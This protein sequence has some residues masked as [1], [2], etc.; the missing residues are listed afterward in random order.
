MKYSDFIKPA[1]SFIGPVTGGDL[2]G[3]EV[4]RLGY[5]QVQ[6]FV[7]CDVLPLDGVI[8]WKVQG[9]DTSGGTFADVTGAAGDKIT[10]EDD[11]IV[12][13][14]DLTNIALTIAAQPSSP[15]R[16]RIEVVDTTP[17][18]TQGDVTIVGTDILDNALTEVVSYTGGAVKITSGVFK[19]IESITCSDFETL[20]GASDETIEVGPDNSTGVHVGALDGTQLPRYLRLV[21][22]NVTGGSGNMFGGFNLSNYTRL[23]DHPDGFG[24]N[25]FVYLGG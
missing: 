21:T 13:A 5:N 17:S 24:G 19:T 20:G 2:N 12:A 23:P 16:L 7:A 4:D 22:A 25:E 9:S 15:A 1:L 6:A 14:V 3:S 11:T 8:D 10:V 18:I